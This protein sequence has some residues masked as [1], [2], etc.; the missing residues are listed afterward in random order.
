MIDSSPERDDWP[1]FLNLLHPGES[2]RTRHAGITQLSG[3]TN[4]ADP[5]NPF[6]AFSIPKRTGG[7]AGKEPA[8]LCRTDTHPQITPRQKIE[9]PPTPPHP[10]DKA[11]EKDQFQSQTILDT[12]RRWS[13]GVGKKSFFWT[14]DFETQADDLWKGKAG[15]VKTRNALWIKELAE[16]CFLK[17]SSQL[18]LTL[19]IA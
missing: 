7:G 1:N 15:N 18:R 5:S 2:F 9:R 17:A 13:F 4:F 19:Q 14:E 12:Q 6:A 3:R 8:S 16:R 11:D 10:S